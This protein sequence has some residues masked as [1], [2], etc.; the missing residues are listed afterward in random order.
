MLQTDFQSASNAVRE[1]ERAVTSGV[2]R[3]SGCRC[4]AL[5]DLAPH[6]GLLPKLTRAEGDLQWKSL[7]DGTPEEALLDGAP[8][9]IELPSAP[10]NAALR[11]E[12]VAAERSSPSVSWL[13]TSLSLRDLFLHVQP[14]LDADMPNGRKALFRFYD[15]RTLTSIRSGLGSDK[16]GKSLFEPISEWWLW[17]S[18]GYRNLLEGFRHA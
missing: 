14:F 10:N 1:F 18:G 15:P 11:R 7:F 6:E 9:L 16:L 2:A 5:L 12:L 8:I 4:F 17:Q 3:P 13:W